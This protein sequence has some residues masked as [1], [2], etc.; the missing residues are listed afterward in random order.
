MRSSRKNY[1]RIETMSLEEDY[2][3]SFGEEEEIKTID[4]K[5]YKS[6]REIPHPPRDTFEV[7]DSY[8]FK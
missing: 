8:R 4:L 6:H 5:E 3:S 7:S 1:Q 2:F